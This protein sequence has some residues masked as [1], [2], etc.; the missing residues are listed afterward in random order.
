LD[1]TEAGRIRADL[2]EVRG[3]LGEP[4]AAARVVE[5]LLGKL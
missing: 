2:A 5:D 4:G 3:H 1:P